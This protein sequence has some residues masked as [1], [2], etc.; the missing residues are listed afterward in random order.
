MPEGLWLLLLFLL[1][2][3]GGWLVERSVQRQGHYCGLVVK[4]PPLVNWLCGNPRGDG[5]LDLDCAVRQLSSLA[6]LVGAPLAFLLPLDQS[7]RAALVFLGYVIL[8]IPGFAL[9]G[10][11]R[12]HSSRR[13][14]RELDGASSVR[15][16]R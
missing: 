5:T 13:L 12:W 15:S 10:W 14:A 8:S 7:R 3:A 1:M 2:G 4:A 11:V 16:A 9:S 6:F